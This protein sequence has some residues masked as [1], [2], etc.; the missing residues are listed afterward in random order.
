[1]GAAGAAIPDVLNSW[2]DADNREV[3]LGMVARPAAA[4]SAKVVPYP[5][6]LVTSS[7]IHA[8]TTGKRIGALPQRRCTFSTGTRASL[9][10]YR[11]DRMERPLMVSLMPPMSIKMTH[12]DD[13]DALLRLNAYATVPTGGM[14]LGRS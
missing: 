4:R 8:A 7:I 11:A 9:G 12:R 14:L 10:K 1:V 13:A 5:S 3:F 6:S 2:H